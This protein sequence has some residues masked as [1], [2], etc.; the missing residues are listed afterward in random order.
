[1]LIERCF[2]ECVLYFQSE[3]MQTQLSAKSK[4]VKELQQEVN[5]SYGKENNY[6][7]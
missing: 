5:I 3:N 6:P 4:Q 7:F 1:M 2:M